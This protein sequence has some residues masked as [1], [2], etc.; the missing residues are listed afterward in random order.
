MDKLSQLID[1]NHAWSKAAKKKDPDF[2]SRT[3]TKQTPSYFWIGCTDS[4]VSPDRITNLPPGELFVH[5]NIANLVIHEDLNCMSA[6][7]YAVEVL[8]I[9]HIIIC[10]HYNCGGIH[11]ALQGIEP[12]LVNNW[13]DNIKPIIESNKIELASLSYEDKYNKLCELNVIEQVY[14]LCQTEIV[15]AA[16]KSNKNL[17]IYSLIYDPCNGKLKNLKVKVSSKEELDNNYI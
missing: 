4:R 12:A 15:Q 11:A 5:R 8:E 13:L 6:L 14:N 3:A 10:G 17:S 2:F 1:N 7:Q 9:E 16:W